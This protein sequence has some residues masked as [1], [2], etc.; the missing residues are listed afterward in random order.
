M[1]ARS[2][3]KNAKGAHGCEGPSLGPTTELGM[4]VVCLDNRARQRISEPQ[5]SFRRQKNAPQR[6]K[7]V[8]ALVALSTKLSQ[9]SLANYFRISF[10]ENG[11]QTTACSLTSINPMDGTFP[12]ARQFLKFNFV[13]CVRRT[14][15]LLTASAT[16]HIQP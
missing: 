13:G 4:A 5:R 7:Q 1:L 10:S 14:I 6:S 11:Q 2:E 9:Q 12:R 8:F 16:F 3:S 15:M